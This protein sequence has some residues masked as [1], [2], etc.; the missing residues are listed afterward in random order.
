MR[1]DMA[2]G[3]GLEVMIPRGKFE[4]DKLE[5]PV[6]QQP[7]QQQ[8]DQWEFLHEEVSSSTVSVPTLFTCPIS[9]ELMNDPV[10]LSTGITYDRASIEKWL[11]DGHC[12]CPATNQVLVTQDLIPNHTLRRLIQDWCV[13]RRFPSCTSPERRQP[14]TIELL[15]QHV[16]RLLKRIAHGFLM[17]DSLKKLRTLAEGVQTDEKSR[18]CIVKA[19]AV[20]ILA[21]AA[22][23]S[24]GGLDACEDSVATIALLGSLTESDKKAM[25]DAKPAMAALCWILSSGSRDGKIDAAE[26]L[27][28]IIVVGVDISSNLKAAAVAVGINSAA[29]FGGG[30][31]LPTAIQGLVCLLKEHRV[32]PRRTVLTSLKC[33]LSLCAHAPKRNRLAAIE[34]DTVGALIQ[35]LGTSE[36]AA[37][38]DHH[39]Q[40][41]CNIEHSFAVLEVLASCAE[42]REAICNQARLVIPLIAKSMVGISKLATEH[43]VA[44]LWAVVSF[45]SGNRQALQTALQSGGAFTKLLMLL[46]SECSVRSKLKAREI[47]NL[48]NPAGDQL[49]WS[50]SYC[51]NYPTSSAPPIYICRPT[52]TRH[53]NHINKT[54][55]HV[56]QQAAALTGMV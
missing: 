8:H 23:G 11:G 17:E 45:S 19:G 6:V 42:G 14:P 20:P 12:T 26:V 55:H 47:L 5:L 44:V 51:S 32:Y 36:T 16:R 4:A 48:L 53:N 1:S 7:Q 28:R 30:A 39:Q 37:A 50:S 21:A 9:L 22:L 15:E 3:A 38:S 13:E 34:A 2:F 40:R 31:G 29:A 54:R 27:E 24:V 49:S 46:P 33:L 41:C 52:H 25:A 56:Q 18:M 35:L 43:A 10:T